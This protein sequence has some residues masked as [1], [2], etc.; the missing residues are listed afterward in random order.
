M[1][2]SIVQLESFK[3]KSTVT[4]L[5]QL[6]LQFTS[7]QSKCC[8][9]SI[10][11]AK[12]F[13]FFECGTRYW[14]W[15]SGREVR[16]S[17]WWSC[18]QFRLTSAI[19]VLCQLLKLCTSWS[20]GQLFESEEHSRCAIRCL[21]SPGEGQTGVHVRYRRPIG[22]LNVQNSGLSFRAIEQRKQLG[23]SK[24]EAR[25]WKYVEVADWEGIPREY[26]RLRER[27][28]AEQ[29][30]AQILDSRFNTLYTG[31]HNVVSTWRCGYQ[32]V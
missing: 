23:A 20:P 24:L 6:S 9:F 14:F 16:V 26:S 22:H 7:L 13:L 8:W 12:R 11:F 30:E 28:S 29:S 2:D 19:E 21:H 25:S 3:C 4:S 17:F 15:S 32:F 1:I 31:K 18:C 5:I 27:I 10:L